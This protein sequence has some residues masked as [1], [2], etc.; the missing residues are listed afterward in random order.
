MGELR[1]SYVYIL[2]STESD[3]LRVVSTFGYSLEERLRLYKL[4]SKRK[5]CNV[6][7]W[8]AGLNYKS[9]RIISM[10]VMFCDKITLRKKEQEFIE[11]YGCDLNQTTAFL[12]KEERLRIS[13]DY[14]ERNKELISERKKSRHIVSAGDG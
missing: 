2:A 11:V 8:V 9:L 7:R 13:R 4:D 1:L 12:G 5:S 10:V 3:K 6:S 14:G